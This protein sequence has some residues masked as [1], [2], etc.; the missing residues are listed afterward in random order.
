[1]LQKLK[2]HHLS[3][4]VP[5]MEKAINFWKDIFGFNLEHSASIDAIPGKVSF[6]ERDGFRIELWEVENALPVPGARK[7]P[8]SDLRTNGTKHIAFEVPDVQAALDELV[9]KG[10]D[11]A[12][13][14]R[15]FTQPMIHEADP[16]MDAN[17]SKRPVVAAFIRDPAGTLIEIIA[18]EEKK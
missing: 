9:K 6:L 5:D 18:S 10:V 2:P 4:S 16:S 11:I 13:V 12:A 3:I 15:D 7:D 8:N 17:Q 14:Q 1:M